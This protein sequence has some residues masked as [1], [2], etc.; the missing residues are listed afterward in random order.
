MKY[1]IDPTSG[2]LYMLDP[3]IPSD[4]AL[5]LQLEAEGYP[6]TTLSLYQTKQQ[7]KSALAETD[8]TEITSVS[9]PS[10]PVYLLNASEFVAYRNQL[11]AIAVDDTGTAQWPTKPTEQWSQ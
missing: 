2:N 1:F 11:R 10:N 4:Q 6:E 7:A 3:E 8:W 5:I 9:N